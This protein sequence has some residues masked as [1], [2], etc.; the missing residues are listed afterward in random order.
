LTSAKARR[1]REILM[2][3][4]ADTAALSRAD[5]AEGRMPSRHPA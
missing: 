1:Y 3:R 5:R 4:P 2:V